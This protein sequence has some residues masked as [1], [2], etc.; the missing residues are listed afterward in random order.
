MG[1]LKVEKNCKDFLNHKVPV[2]ILG[3][4]DYAK[5]VA[6][7]INFDGFID[8]YTNDLT[9]MQKPVI[10]RLEL[11]PKNAIIL[12]CIIGNK[13]LTVKYKIQKQ[14]IESIDYF[15][16]LKY[17]GLPIKPIEFWIG[18]HE[19]YVKNEENYRKILSLLTDK[20]SKQ[21]FDK[22]V[23]FRLSYDLT[24]MEGF[25]DIQYKQYFEDFLNLQKSG[26]VFVDV[27]GYD[28][29]TS[30][31]F[32][33][34]CPDFSKIYFFEPDSNNLKKAQNVMQKYSNIEYFEKGLSNKKESLRFQNELG[35]SSKV[36][37]NGPIVIEADTLDNLI[38]DKVT[39]IKMDIEGSEGIAI[40]GAK[41]TI[42]KYHPRL[43]ICVYHKAN[44]LIAIPNQVLAIRSDYEIYLR[45][46]TEGVVETVMFFIP[47]K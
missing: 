3:R 28:G 43:A 30:L 35:S 46:Y 10:T 23:N 4:N 19:G 31:E 1:I 17:S 26:E 5:S 7:I 6:E 41:Q 20:T 47:G 36:S 18:F 11:V 8:E 37:E 2:Y 45:H 33:K 39:F 42:L 22:I 27:G 29:Y 13:P 9:F 21:I 25:E 34:R 32:I 40:E 24:Y 38:K 15:A 12:F 14:L 44:D 16:F